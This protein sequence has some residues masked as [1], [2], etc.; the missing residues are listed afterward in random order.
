MEK[1]NPAK[2]GECKAI[3]VAFRVKAT[4]MFFM[5]LLFE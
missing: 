4:S 5:Y 3:D 2:A 1:F